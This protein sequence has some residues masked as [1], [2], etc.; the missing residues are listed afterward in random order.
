MQVFLSDK[1]V[2]KL[3]NQNNKDMKRSRSN[4]IRSANYDSNE[5]EKLTKR[6]KN[7]NKRK[8][9]MFSIE[10]NKINFQYNNKVNYKELIKNSESEYSRAILLTENTLNIQ[11]ENFFERLK[12]RQHIQMQKSSDNKL[13]VRQQSFIKRK[14][15]SPDI[16]YSDS[17]RKNFMSLGI[18]NV[19]LLNST[20]KALFEDD[21]NN[22]NKTINTNKIINTN[23]TNNTNNTTKRRSIRRNSQKEIGNL[24]ENYLGKFHQVFF[25]NW[26]RTLKI[27]YEMINQAYNRRI[28][29][30]LEYD[31][32][33]ME[34]EMMIVDNNSKIKFNKF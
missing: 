21:N 6:K 24:I 9:A 8:S 34:F 15:I 18:R 17:S 11:R 19:N 22:T 13:N 33:R 2:I 7:S 28:E 32:Q 31:D 1:I 20:K 12:R 26:E 16:N 14:N 30:Y 25:N 4:L 27:F 10:I 3:M 23:N 29:K 5:N